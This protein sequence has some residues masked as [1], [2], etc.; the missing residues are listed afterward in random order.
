[1]KDKTLKT[2]EYDKI[3]NM[4]AAGASSAA[5]KE[6]LLALCP[7]TDKASVAEALGE[8][9]EAVSV[10]VRKGNAPLGQL[11]D[12]EGA[13]SFAKKG[14]SLTMKQLLQILYNIKVA[15][16]VITFLKSDLPDLPV[17][18]GIRDALETFPRLEA[19][20]D[21]CIL[22]EDEMA[23]NA[24]PKLR[25]IRRSIHRQND[26]IKNR[27]NNIL[28]S[29]DN[30]TYLQDAIVTIRDGRYVVP[31]KAEHRARFPGIIHDQSS[32]G[33]T[34]FIEPQVIVNLNNEL[35]ELEL[36]EQVEIERILA[37]LSAN[38]AEHYAMIMNNQK[39]LIML[40]MIF[41]KGKLSMAMKGEEPHITSD[42]AIT[43]RQARHP[44]IDQKKAVPIDVSVGDGYTTLVVTGPNTGGKTV[45][46]KTAGLLTLMA[47]SGLHI[48]ASSQ[49]RIA[50]FDQVYAD[51]GDEQSIEQNL[52][53]FS[54]HMK[55]IVEILQEAGKDC[56]VL[57]DELGAGTDPTEGA[58]LAIS[59]LEN[60]KAWG[61]RTIAT[62]HY[63]EL[64]KYALSTDGV[65]NGSMEFDVETLSPTY[66]LI[67]GVPGRS[68][69][70]EISRK[71]GLPENIIYRASQLLERGDIE[72]ESVLDAI[73][74]D[75]KKAE[76]D[77]RQAASLKL[78][79]QHLYDE[80]EQRQQDMRRQE[81][82]MISKAREEARDIL[83]EARQT[84]DDVGR[85]LRRINKMSDVRDM[86]R[87]FDRSRRKLRETESRFA[88]KKIKRVNQSPVDASQLKVGDKVR[89]VTLDQVGE[90]MTLPDDKGDLQVKIGMMKVNINVSDLMFAEE[91]KNAP[92]KSQSRYGGLSLRKAKT[93]SPAI[94]VQG[95]N[96]EDA[97]MDVDKY[98][99][100]AY[101]A[102][103]KEVTVIHGR[104]EGILKEG[105]R[106]AFRKH[107]LVASFRKGKYDEG[108]DG[109]T[110]VTLK[111]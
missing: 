92:D 109:V 72:F 24:S 44:L 69:A 32:T 35:R 66:R 75:R 27:L 90:V 84:A 97:M 31:V 74:R 101:M 46:L 111:E 33:A 79:A 96:L 87:S 99:D 100:D 51:I 70:F 41:A 58:A 77:R 106:R 30:K 7:M 37:E 21:R 91:Q 19:N 2:L 63:N 53:T 59:I 65:E 62:T 85:E 61:A 43:L 50:I 108:G 18:D 9:T 23:D 107:K 81:D 71:L 82:R 38:V 52:S 20:I 103:L 94:N 25:D 73:E 48:P 34:I 3:L 12:I 1:M 98:L 45:T 110:I 49:S 60:L 13:M 6:K 76:E 42:G 28:N 64:K 55:N 22:S 16:N 10:I 11:Y 102:G 17:I 40:D 93:I 95:E 86:N 67:T 47:Q 15:S 39:L 54:S 105:L 57:L 83:K 56:L 26:A 8:T 78:S 80:M 89:V 36:A 5:A 88:E 29:Q 68:N 4:L 104:G 14:G